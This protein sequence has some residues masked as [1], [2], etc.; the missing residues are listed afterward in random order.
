MPEAHYIS[1]NDGGLGIEQNILTLCRVKFGDVSCHDVYDKGPLHTRE[2]M[3]EQFR[4]YLSAY[5]AD[6]EWSEDKLI[7]KKEF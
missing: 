1:R 2:R 4:S 5:Y 3:R 7:Y 6:W